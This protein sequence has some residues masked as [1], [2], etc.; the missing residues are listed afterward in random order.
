[1]IQEKQK[2]LDEVSEV[3]DARADSLKKIWYDFSRKKLSVMGLVLVVIVVFLALLGPYIAPHSRHAGAFVDFPNANQAPSVAHPFGTD[4]VG[5]D[6]LTRVL[7]ALRPALMMGVIVLGISVPI[8][9]AVGLVAGYWRGTLVEVI[10]MRVTDIFLA[11]PPLVLALAIA[12][13]LTPNLRNAMLAITVMWWPWY[14]R[15]V[16][17]VSSSLRN[18]FFVR[19]A[20]LIG[21]RTGHIIIREML[22]NCLLPVFTKMTLDMAWVIMISA[23]LSFVGLGE[24]PPA[25]ALGS[26]VADGSKYMPDQWWMTVFPALTIMVIVLSFNLLGDGIRDAFAVGEER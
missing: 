7:F 23:S 16:Y 24:Q 5:R 20:E 17:G 4:N 22:P 21:A 10:I 9:T 18:E 6:I 2:V 26:M 12:S 14:A 15:L 1:M 13:V 8:G 11:I 25:P 3:G 19:S